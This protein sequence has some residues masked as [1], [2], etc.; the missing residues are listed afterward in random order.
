VIAK[1]IC[2]SAIMI[3]WLQNPCL[4]A[5]LT[6]LFSLYKFLPYSLLE[7]MIQ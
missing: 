5:F 6:G 1:F 2:V 4:F 7:I 3:S